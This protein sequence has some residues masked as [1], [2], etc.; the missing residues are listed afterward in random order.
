MGSSGMNADLKKFLDKHYLSSR[1]DLMTCFMQRAMNFCLSKGFWGMINLPSWMFLSTFE[2]FRKG[3]IVNNKFDSMLHLGRGIFGSDFGSIAFTMNHRIP[4][5]IEKGV[6]R[7]LFKEHV[8][9]RAIE[10][11]KELFFDRSYGYYESNQMDFGKIPGSPIG[12]WIGPQFIDVFKRFKPLKEK[13]FCIQ[14]IITGNTEKLLRFWSEVSISNIQIDSDKFI[15]GRH[16]ISY[17]KGGEQRKWFGN[18]SYVINWKNKGQDL[19]R[20]R[21]TNSSYYLKPCL[22]W[23]LITSAGFSAR[24]CDNGFLWD[25][26]GSIGFPNQK[27]EMNFIL[28]VL[29]SKISAYC[30]KLLNPTI[31][32]NIEN[33]EA[34]PIPNLQD[35]ELLKTINII[36]GDCIDISKREWDSHETSWDFQQ[37]ELIKQQQHSVKSAFEIY[38]N[39][40]EEKFYK[41]KENEEK[42]NSLF[43]EI[44]CLQNELTPEVPLKEITILQE[45]SKIE[46]SKLVISPLPVLLQ[47][48]SYSTG[49]LFGR[50]S[51]NKPGLL[52]A[53][54]GETLQDFLMQIPAPT[55]LPDED[56][57]I[58]VLDEEWFTDDIVGRFKVFLK[59]AFGE[60]HFEENLR[61]IEETIG[62]DIR[63][64]FVKDFYNDHI[65]RYKKRPIYWMFSSPKGHFKALIYMHRY[66]PDL[67]SKMLNDYLQ[68]FISKLEAAKQTQT[69][70][71]LREDISAR[72]K[73]IAIKEIDKY[74]AMLKDCREYEKILFTIATQKISIDLDDGVK[75]N[76]HKFKEALVPIKGLEKEED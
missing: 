6:Y 67:C 13:V 21:N 55:F 3:L 64:Y 61:Y 25:V 2:K 27:K 30:I 68:A 36:S 24:Y 34:I 71:S 52:L 7:R 22:T 16:W 41:L 33:I 28:S 14:G 31:N 46:N 11:I 37:N 38:Q 69:M 51:I 56:N 35:E 45:E 1:A 62:K 76:Y 75:V 70:L 5:I 50:Y 73:A 9:V 74:E 58:P 18:N 66:Q 49:C 20:S 29:C 44:Y 32:T 47:L 15:S 63:K 19:I 72:E 43:I 23:T 17:T 57:I 26:S 8:Q 12:Y 10:T 60:A 4:S 65:K 40:W 39:L 48:I 59:V 54:K 53:T 42:L